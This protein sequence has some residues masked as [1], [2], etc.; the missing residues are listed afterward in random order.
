MGWGPARSGGSPPPAAIA[1]GSG[2]PPTVLIADDDPEIVRLLA[3]TLR[4]EGLRLLSAE[5]GASALQ[6]ARAERPALILMDW[7]MPKLDGLAVCRALRA[8]E[9]PR[10]R[11]VS[12]VLITAQTGPENTAAGFEAGV[13]DYLTKPFTPPQVRARVR[14]WLLR[15][16]VNT[17]GDR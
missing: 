6:L 9:D 4:Q 16:G 12:V 5:D 1:G 13:T 11:D 17:A 10:L 8:E 15:A 3:L 7:Q 14:T 2:E